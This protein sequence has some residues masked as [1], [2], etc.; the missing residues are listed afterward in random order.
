MGMEQLMAL[1]TSGGGPLIRQHLGGQG[2]ATVT[3]PWGPFDA[4][5][6]L[7]LSCQRTI[8]FPSKYKT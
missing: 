2:R 6:L 5:N 3:P 4:G 7:S 8:N 1:L